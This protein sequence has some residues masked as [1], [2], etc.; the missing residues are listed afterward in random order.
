MSE[1][2]EPRL[3]LELEFIRASFL[4]EFG[5]SLCIDFV[6]ESN[7]GTDFAPFL[8]DTGIVGR[9]FAELAENVKSLIVTTFA[10]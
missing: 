1:A 9:E 8:E 5:M 10:C 3:N 6:V 4:L 2:V 7:F